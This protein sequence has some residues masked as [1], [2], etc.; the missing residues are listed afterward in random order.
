MVVVNVHAAVND[1]EMAELYGRILDGFGYAGAAIIVLPVDRLN[2]AG[3]RCRSLLQAPFESHS[4]CVAALA[5]CPARWLT[6]QRKDTRRV[7]HRQSQ[8]TL[9]RSYESASNPTRTD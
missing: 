3:G 5:A 9:V 1:S 4:A 2:D 6:D 7:D 8:A